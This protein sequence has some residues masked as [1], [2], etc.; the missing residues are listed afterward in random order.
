MKN[1]EVIL[2]IIRF[3]LIHYLLV[4]LQNPHHAE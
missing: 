2:R 4:S 3:A 1:I